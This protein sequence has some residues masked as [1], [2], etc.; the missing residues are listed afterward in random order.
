MSTAAG[1]SVEPS[2]RVA[3]N[4]AFVFAGLGDAVVMVDTEEGCYYELN[5]VGAEIWTR[6]ESGARVAVVIEALIAQYDVAPEVCR[7]EVSAFLA[8][9]LRYGAV[10]VEPRIGDAPPEVLG[11]PDGPLPTGPGGNGARRGEGRTW[12]PPTVRVM[13]IGTVTHSGE[14]PNPTFEGKYGM[15]IFETELYPSQS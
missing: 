6:I 5:R 9:L 7:A 11:T 3:Q 13:S 10:L 2:S 4:Q 14:N 8:E 15:G 12:T 1:V